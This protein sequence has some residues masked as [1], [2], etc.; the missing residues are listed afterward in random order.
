MD[1]K[2]Q[3]IRVQ[4]LTL[5]N[6]YSIMIEEEQVPVP[7][8]ERSDRVSAIFNNFS[9]PIDFTIP[10]S[11]VPVK[12]ESPVIKIHRKISP[13]ILEFNPHVPQVQDHNKF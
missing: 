8:L 3:I 1:A 11:S 5:K 7:R 6:E 13:R 12:S 4:D 10:R 2:T 9:L